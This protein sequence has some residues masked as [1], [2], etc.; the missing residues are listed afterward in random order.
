MARSDSDGPSHEQASA[1]QL[2]D[3]KDLEPLQPDRLDRE[4]VDGQ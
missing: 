2:D 1:A 3:E 4:E